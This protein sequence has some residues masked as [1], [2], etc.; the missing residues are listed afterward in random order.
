MTMDIRL[1]ERLVGA[2]VLVLAAVIF[3]PMVLDGPD[4]SRKVT[5]S[6]ALPDIDASAS[7]TVRVEL[8]GPA[9]Q[10]AADATPDELAAVDLVPAEDDDAAAPAREPARDAAATRPATPAA[11]TTAEPAT[12]ERSAWTVQAGSFSQEDNAE[13]LAAKLRKL[14][15]PAYVS[16]FVDGD[17]I[18]YRVR[19][20]GFTSRDAAQ[21]QAD[22]I[23][24]KSGEPAAPTPNQ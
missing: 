15:F 21:R 24:A 5:R 23:R 7:R 3:I 19:S 8:D 9:P 18:H 4:G 13:A 2:V 17:R 20:G 6:V 11:V 14:G 16:R 10:A 12:S 22:E 1:K